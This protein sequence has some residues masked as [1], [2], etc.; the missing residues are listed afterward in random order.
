MAFDFSIYILKDK[1]TGELCRSV[2]LSNRVIVFP[3]ISQKKLPISSFNMHTCTFLFQTNIC[4]KCRVA[5]NVIRNEFKNRTNLDKVEQVL[6]SL[7]DLLTVLSDTVCR[8]Y[9]SIY[10]VSKYLCGKLLKTLALTYAIK[11]RIIWY[12]VTPNI[13]TIN[14]IEQDALLCSV[15]RYVK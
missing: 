11:F 5:S 6:F 13:N 2:A 1:R 7:C 15:R 12:F 4:L 14:K 8:G 9:A 3:K 10:A